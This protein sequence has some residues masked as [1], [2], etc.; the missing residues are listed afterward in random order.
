MKQTRSSVAL[1]T[2][3][4]AVGAFGWQRAT[5]AA[6]ADTKGGTSMKVNVRDLDPTGKLTAVK[7][8]PKVVK[9]DAEW[10]AQLT[11]EQ[12]RIAR[13]QGTEPAFCGAFFDNHKTGLYTCICCGLPLFESSA[14]FDSGTGWPS[15]IT[16]ICPENV[17]TRVDRAFG[18]VRTEILCTRC[19]AHLGHVFD[20]G[21]PPTGL[22]YC[23][24]SAALTFVPAP[25][26]PDQP[27][28][29]P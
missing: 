18:M 15:F 28:R 19:D 7:S 14:K 1:L 10:R 23:L 29:K 3:L 24:N 9:T 13:G 20:D 11:P 8:M 26:G 21:P 27:A 16:P 25:H 17:T 4:A 12:Y 5:A 6:E 2:F 22:R